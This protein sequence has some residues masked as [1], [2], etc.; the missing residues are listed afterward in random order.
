VVQHS[1]IGQSMT[2]DFRKEVEARVA[3][4]ATN[5]ALLEARD[6]FMRESIAARYSYNFSWMGRPIIQYP[7]DMVA[8]QELIWATKPDVIVETGIAHGGSL[9]LSASILA[10]LDLCDHEAA[11][12]GSAPRMTRRHVVGVD[13]DIR[14][15]NRLAIE[16]HPMSGRITTIQGS[17]IDP[18]VFNQVRQS[19]G[20]AERVL[21]M[22]DSNHT[23]DHVLAELELYAPL[24]SK[25]SYCIVFDTLVE[26]LPE[27][28]AFGRPWGLGNNPMTAVHT[29][30]KGRTDFVMDHEIEAKNVLTV[31]PDGFLRRVR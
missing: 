22:L 16:A 1:S 2:S 30:I 23:H 25:G 7:Q 24:T 3:E 26:R 31:A 21:V 18:G 19:V 28:L 12:R 11:G 27:E 14:E 8:V 9:V 20:D 10:L 5:R 17:S 13:I 15:H 6:A 4:N 29:W